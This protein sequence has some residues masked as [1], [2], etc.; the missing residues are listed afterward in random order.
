MAV[1]ALYQPSERVHLE[2]ITIR[3]VSADGCDRIAGKS[4]SRSRAVG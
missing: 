2:N 1:D 3:S 4:R